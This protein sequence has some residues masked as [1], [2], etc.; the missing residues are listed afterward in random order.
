[1][2]SVSKQ[3]NN[4]FEFFLLYG[5]E[6]GQLF[7]F[8]VNC[9]KIDSDPKAFAMKLFVFTRKGNSRQPVWFHS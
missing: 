8:L 5:P 7:P 2:K 3:H 9:Q 4:N 6:F 1:M